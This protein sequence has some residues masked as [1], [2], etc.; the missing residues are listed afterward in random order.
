MKYDEKFQI[1]IALGIILLIGE[2]LIS[3]RKRTV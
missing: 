3:E 2:A 1:F